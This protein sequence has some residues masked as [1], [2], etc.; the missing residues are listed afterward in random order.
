MKRF[1]RAASPGAAG[2][3]RT[4]AGSGALAAGLLLATLLPTA[5]RA[6]FSVRP[7][8]LEL[9]ASGETTVVV[10][11]ES[12]DPLAFRITLGD[13]DQAE[14]GAHRFLPFGEH[15]GSCAGRL[16]TFPDRIAVDPGGEGAI[17]ITLAPGDRPC[18]SAVYVEHRPEP[19]PGRSLAIRRVAVQVTGAGRGDATVDAAIRDVAVEAGPDGP[20]VTYVFENRGEAPLR[21]RGRLE[22][23]TLEGEVVAI[24]RLDPFGVLPGRAR[25]RS[26]PLPEGLPPGSL[27]AVPILDFGADHLVGGRALFEHE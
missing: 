13:Y 5:A 21:P 7:A 9:D 2:L 16:E 15:P 10:R 4:F 3:R 22:V 23:R 18:W 25:I 12:D 1:R 27:L 19:V 24:E 11:N 26:V 17:R 8:V 14:S 6:Q 20:V